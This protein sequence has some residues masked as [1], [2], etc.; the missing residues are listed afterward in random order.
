M[1]QALKLK[2]LAHDQIGQSISNFKKKIDLPNRNWNVGREI[3]NRKKLGKKRINQ[4]RRVF[5]QPIRAVSLIKKKRM[6][7]LVAYCYDV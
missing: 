1:I 6:N 5:I 2:I 3:Q 4:A 7:N